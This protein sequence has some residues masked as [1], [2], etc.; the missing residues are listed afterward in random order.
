M[1]E[2]YYRLR[3]K[4][5]SLLPDPE[6]LMLGR[7]H[8][9][10]LS[11]LQYG[12]TNQAGFTVISGEV[13]CGKTTLIRHLLNVVDD[14]VTV[15][16]ISD[17][18]QYQGEL[19]RRILLAFGQDFNLETRTGLFDRFTEFLI[20]EFAQGRRTVLIVDEAQ[21]LDA[22]TLEELRTLS[23]I[24][25]DKSQILQLILVGQ[26]ELRETLKRS[27]MRQFA[28]RIAVD[29][30]IQPLDLDETAA[31]IAHRLRVAGGDPETFAPA[32]V[33]LVHKHSAGVPRLINVL[34]D[35]ALVYGFGAY[36]EV[37][38]DDL[39]NE[40]IED[41]AK[42]G[43]FAHTTVGA[44]PVDD[45]DRQA[46]NEERRR[47]RLADGSDP[48][49][50]AIDLERTEP[51]AYI[52]QGSHVACNQA[53]ADLFGFEDTTQVDGVTVVDLI[54]PEDRNLVRAVLERPGAAGSV[55]L[56]GLGIDRGVF[57]VE[58]EFSPASIEGEHCTRVRAKKIDVQAVLSGRG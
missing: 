8:S 9:M 53:Y 47:T 1:Y 41:K 22:S 51:L 35:T 13:G 31:Y 44:V 48:M 28:Q 57:P 30:H 21:N 40:V 18:N 50:I 32:A 29:Y 7:K 24:N 56:N 14:D 19:L 39:M 36:K 27:E 34:C 17:T 10:A 15:G 4:P 25:A 5:F 38:N 55:S 43:L 58:I 2:A 45:Q 11:M 52:H 26:P 20:E 12:L 46:A 54:A 23:N 6:F 37:I 49:S 42:S 3:E 33:R 16:L